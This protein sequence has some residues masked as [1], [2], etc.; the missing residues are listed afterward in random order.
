MDV[1][2]PVRGE[3]S[4]EPEREQPKADAIAPARQRL[5]LPVWRPMICTAR[6]G[7]IVMALIAEMIVETAIVTANWRKN[8]PVMPPMNAARHEHARSAPA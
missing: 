2:R 3:R 1:A 5:V 8:C 4:A 6:E 7:V